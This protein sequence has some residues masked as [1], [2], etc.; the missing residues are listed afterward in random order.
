MVLITTEKEILKR[1]KENLFDVASE[2]G[3]YKPI[4]IKS[5]FKGSYKYYESREDKEKRLP[6]RQYFNKL[7]RIY[8]I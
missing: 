1:E 5:S 8:M 2:E 6:V 3:Y 7:H 4:L